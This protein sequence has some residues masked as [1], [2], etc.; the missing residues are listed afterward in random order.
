M[1][2]I[3]FYSGNS[4]LHD[5][6]ATIPLNLLQYSVLSFSAGWIC[7]SQRFWDAA[8]FHWQSFSGAVLHLTDRASAGSM[9]L[10]Q[11][12][13][14]MD[15]KEWV[16]RKLQPIIK[17]YS[18]FP[19]EQGL[20]VTDAKPGKAFSEMLHLHLWQGPCAAVLAAQQT[21]LALMPAVWAPTW[22][23]HSAFHL[24]LPTYLPRA[25]S[26]G[27]QTKISTVTIHPQTSFLWKSKIMHF[28]YIIG[29]ISGK[30]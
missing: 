12:I 25:K 6:R 3:K 9:T 11:G 2:K 17:Q 16:T 5:N 28:R 10:A 13:P 29:L 30:E 14:L 21:R 19:S 20:E 26:S 27:F 4:A 23:P 22:Q 15:L 18:F 8:K 1:M 24:R 7:F